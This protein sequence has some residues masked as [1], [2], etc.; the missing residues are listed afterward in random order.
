MKSFALIL[1]P[2]AL[3]AQP[4]VAAPLNTDGYGALALASVLALHDPLLTAANKALLAQYLDG[5]PGAPHPAGLVIHLNTGA[6][7]CR[8]GDVDLAMHECT[9]HYGLHTLTLTGRS[10]HELYATMAEAG[11]PSDGAA[12]SIFEGVNDLHCTINADEIKDQSGGGAHC[13]YTQ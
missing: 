7:A 6:I 2:F 5:H 11:I 1:T 10:A 4:A 8:A 3:L 9:I 12:G 13:T